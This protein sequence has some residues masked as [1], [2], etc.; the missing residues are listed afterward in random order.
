MFRW[1]ER[2]LTATQASTGKPVYSVLE[3][4]K[5]EF[6]KSA[7]D[8]YLNYYDVSFAPL[9]V[10][11]PYLSYQRKDSWSG[12][13]H[14][15]GDE[16]FVT[17]D[18]RSPKRRVR[19]TD[20]FSAESVRA[21][22]LKD[23]VVQRVLHREKIAPPPTLDGLL[24]ALI[25]QQFG[26]DD[27]LMYFFPPHL[28]EDFAFYHVENGKVAVRFLLRHGSEVYRFRT[29]QLG[30]LLPI[31]GKLK[32]LFAQAAAGK[33][34]VLMQ[35]LKRSAGDRLTTSVLHNRKDTR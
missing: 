17:I 29:T 11:G 9:S 13:A 26:G 25:N 19:L 22:L 5:Q 30:L 2:D 33:N 28:L 12:G 7:P 20:L 14:P 15:S 16:R 3:S 24:K 31:P 32:T 4:V 35:S 34:G 21:A 23:P 27:D 6:R 18:V 8:D 1:D 10:V